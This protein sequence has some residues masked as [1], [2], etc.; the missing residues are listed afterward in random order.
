MANVQVVAREIEVVHGALND[1]ALDHVASL[2]LDH[3]LTHVRID[4][5]HNLNTEGESVHIL[6]LPHDQFQDRDPGA[7]FMVLYTKI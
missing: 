5:G 2:V 1:R 6:V 3:V 4:I 7:H